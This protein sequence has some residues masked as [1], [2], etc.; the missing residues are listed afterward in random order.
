MFIPS[1]SQAINYSPFTAT[2]E[3]PVEDVITSMSLTGASCVLIVESSSPSNVVRTPPQSDR[4]TS[5]DLSN[6]SKSQDTKLQS[7]GLIIGIF[8]EQDLVQLASI[9][10]SLSGFPI[11]QIMIRS[12]ITAQLSE[13]PDIFALLAILE[14]HQITHLPIVNEAEELIGLVTTR[15]LIFNQ[16]QIKDNSLRLIA[17]RQGEPSIDKN[18]TKVASQKQELEA[19]NNATKTTFDSSLTLPAN[20]IQ[21]NQLEQIPESQIIQA[22]SSLSIRQITQLMFTY[23]I[24]YILITES[25]ENKSQ[26][27]KLTK[28]LGTISSRDIV[29]LQAL[30]IDFNQTKAETV[31]NTL[32]VLVGSQ[33]SLEVALGLMKKNY[34]LLPLIVQTPTGKIT[35]IITATKII[36][37][38]LL[39]KSL[40]QSLIRFH[41][42]IKKTSIQL[43]KIDE[44][45][46][47]SA[48]E[49][50]NLEK[51]YLK[52]Q[53]STVI[54]IEGNQDGVWDWNIKTN[55]IFYSSQWKKLLGYRDDEISHKIDE[56]LNRIH[57]KD[58]EKV[59]AAV[60]EHLAKKSLFYRIEYRIKRKNNSFIWVLDRG[61]TLWQSG[62]PVRMVGSLIDITQFK[63]TEIKLKFQVKKYTEIVDNIQEIAFK[64]DA[65]GN[66]IF[67]NETWK[68]ITGFTC[69]NSLGRN[70]LE[71]IHPEDRK[72]L[73]S[74]AENTPK[75]IELVAS[76]KKLVAGCYQ[77]KW[78]TKNGN[79]CS[80]EMKSTLIADNKG[81]IT[82]MVSTL[83]DISARIATQENL[84]ANEKAIR[85]LYEV[86]TNADNSFESKIVALLDMG[87]R[88]FGMD[89][90]LLGKVLGERYEVIAAH[91]PEDFL[92]GIAK[93]DAFA[94]QQTFDREVLR[95]NEPLAI[96]SAKNSQ[97]R[98]HPAYT[99]R[100]VESY[101]GT[102][103]FVSGRIYGTLSFTS[104]FAKNQWNSTDIEVLK[105]MA[106]YI[107]GELLRQDAIETLQKKYQ[108]ILLLKQITQEIRSKLD[109]QE[110]FQTTA[111][112]IGRVFGVNRCSIHN[113]LSQPYPHLPCVAEYLET[114]YESTLD[115]DIVV[116]YNSHTEKLLSEDKAIATAD[117]F[118]D[119]LLK[120]SAPMYR[121]L[122][123]R[124]MLAVRT[125]YQ[126]QPNGIINLHQC[127]YMRQWTQDEIDLLENV[128]AQVGLTLAQAHI[129]ESEVTHKQQLEAQNQALEQARQAAEVANRA[130]SEFLAMMSHEIRTPMNGVIGMT[131]L[132]LDMELTTEQRDFVETIR[133]SGDALLTI[134]NDILDFTKI[135]SGKLELEQSSLD[136]RNC[137]EE[138]LE[139]LA[140]RA[141]HKDLELACLID[142]SVPAMI[143][144][145]VTRLRQV[146]V[147][148]LGN[149]VKFTE[150]GEVVVSLTARKVCQNNQLED[151]NYEGIFNDKAPSKTTG[152]YDIQFAVK[153]T[154][155][156][157]PPGHMDRLFKAFSQVDAST[158]REYGGTGLGLVISQRLSEIM[159]GKM[160]VVSQWKETDEL[161]EK[162][163]QIIKSKINHNN[164]RINN[165]ETGLNFANSNTVKSLVNIAGSPPPYFVKPEADRKG[166]TFYFTIQAE[167]IT[168]PSSEEIDTFLKGKKLLVVE[169]HPV[170]QEVIKQQV[171][172]WEMIPIIADSGTKALNWLKQ[173]RDFDIGIIAMNLSDMDGLTLARKIRKL[174][175][176]QNVEQN[177]SLSLPLLMF[178]YLGKAEIFRELQEAKV[179]LAGFLNKPVKQSQ[180]YN[181]LLQVF[182]TTADKIANAKT[183]SLG[184]KY[185]QRFS[186]RSSARSHLRILLA[187]DNV[188][189]QKV[190]IHLLGRIGYRADVAANGIEV[191]DALK[192]VPYD[193][194]LMDVQMPEMD[195]IETTSRIHQDY[196]EEKRPWIIAMTANAMQG[197]RDK[198]LNAGMDDYVTKP[199][200]RDQLVEVLNKCKLPI[201][202]EKSTPRNDSALVKRDP[203]KKP[204]TYKQKFINGKVQLNSQ[205]EEKALVKSIFPTP[206]SS[207]SLLPTNDDET[208]L[209]SEAGLQELAEL[210]E[211]LIDLE[212]APETDGVIA[213]DLDLLDN[214]L[215]AEYEKKSAINPKTLA[216]FRNLYDDEPDTL[217][218]LIQDYLVDGNKHMDIIR[219]SIKKHDYTA[220]KGASH[221]LKSSSALLGAINFSELC[222]ELEHM[223]RAVVESGADFN[224]KKA[225]E[226]L[227]LVGAEWE[228]V[229]EE[230]TQEIQQHRGV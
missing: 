69:E 7:L 190:A 227:S 185:F 209:I 54:A 165:R 222:Q 122:N 104:R 37:Q 230:L 203:P 192:R 196:P 4:T 79:Y 225:L 116:T 42:Y 208:I 151:M 82:G 202:N 148:L 128:A 137:V 194:V 169:S 141:A 16:L 9:S 175:T 124:S 132:L 103:I 159:G 72:K 58:I 213:E 215:E 34:Y 142:S 48:V 67:L 156:G 23:N 178:T 134:I 221:T 106:T 20:L 102:K 39:P 15:S 133:T 157:I 29:Q 211:H 110:I 118:S 31:C 49:R 130:K 204:V 50:K 76:N 114:G 100:R 92:F 206:T 173:R 26:N 163:R 88:R 22:A 21:I 135:E 168:V 75:N 129:L 40:Y 14:K 150:K 84:Q 191:L 121:R 119:L 13:I 160:W 98:H 81:N 94:L 216:D 158:T 44:K 60:Q 214:I 197:D 205:L 51:V 155:I 182:G 170:N 131:S 52:T 153:D 55:E 83:S 24:S 167:A 161:K 30:K 53:E 25:K 64:T 226:I 78:L 91:L 93:G 117:I 41:N 176:Q 111:T 195:G 80:V 149:A 212:N 198:C 1:I 27:Q 162:N 99:V 56:W 89:I 210:D 62:I 6:G 174:E 184:L 217:I 73:N 224:L 90:G 201:R 68:K 200:R 107:G 207:S 45:F 32:P 12:I 85:E 177:Y 188:I 220:L 152:T 164:S 154:G 63:E 47:Q 11:A 166:S 113:Y 36:Q 125:S 136:I 189:N 70:Y 2:P 120:S 172:S 97:W 223:T 61:K 140:P 193:V 180:F 127:D 179:N 199:I 35:N 123:V 144:G 228:R 183:P 17:N 8:T 59:S 145:D 10:A 43:Q 96:R 65:T 57:P 66:L 138:A 115:L 218:I 112:Q 105:L 74:S 186:E 126:G 108:H 19:Q 139:L 86:T 28:I 95:S 219:K 147:N 33:A 181:V 109:T 146:L 101:L 171:N 143:V 5:Q 46:K 18:G 87:C 71:F 77:L 187:E 229:K 38:I 3:T